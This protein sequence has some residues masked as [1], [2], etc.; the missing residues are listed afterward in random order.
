M[1]TLNFFHIHVATNITVWLC[2]VLMTFLK[3]LASKSNFSVDIPN[4]YR[5][6]IQD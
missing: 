5:L 4:S 2:G 1:A 3:Y 6:T